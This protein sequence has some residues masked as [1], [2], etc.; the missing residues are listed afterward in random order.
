M[1]NSTVPL[2]VPFTDGINFLLDTL[3]LR[4]AALYRGRFSAPWGISFTRD[5]GQTGRQTGRSANAQFH[6]VLSGSPCYIT[7]SGGETVMLQLG[8][9]VLLPHA[10]A[11]TLKSDAT[12]AATPLERA[13]SRG[14]LDGDLLSFGGGGAPTETLCGDI[15]FAGEAH[16]TPV[17]LAH[18]LLA[19][20]P[21]LMVLRGENGVAL[22]WL[23][24]TLDFLRCEIVSDR[25]GNQTVINRLAEILFIQA[26]R[27]HL[28][29]GDLNCPNANYLRALVEPRIAPAMLAMHTRPA[30]VWSVASLAALCYVSRSAF[31]QS[32]HAQVGVAPLAYLTQWRLFLAGRYLRGT[33][34]ITV[35]EIAA[36]VGYGSEAALS[37]VFKTHTG[38]VPGEYRKRNETSS[39]ALGVV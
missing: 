2:P 38:F 7:V 21:P 24:A 19:A 20:L 27:S 32:F 31:A 37:K 23:G 18:P 1:N 16:G 29:E 14:V 17:T 25:P 39:S 6:V 3:S 30:I 35:G 34:R 22:P 26:V 9:F 13:L 36:R 5:T 12:V 10:D 28:A 11:H 4:G 8:D 15:Y 33:E